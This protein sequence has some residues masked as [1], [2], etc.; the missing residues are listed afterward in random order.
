MKFLEKLYLLMKDKN[1]GKSALCKELEINSNSFVNWENRGTLPS[2]DVI[3]KLANY[4]DVTS[5]YL[6]GRTDNPQ[7]HEDI[8]TVFSEDKKN[9][10]DLYEQLH[11]DD[12]IRI[13][14]KMET[15]IE[16]Y[17]ESKGSVS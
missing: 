5:D 9:L 10:L 1:I 6:L 17:P 12:K 15:I 7:A 11:D 14:T 3:I 4:F 13:I 2:A 16:D 8:S